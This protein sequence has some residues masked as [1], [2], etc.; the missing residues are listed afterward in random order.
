MHK[1]HT[2]HFRILIA[3]A[4][5]ATLAGCGAPGVELLQD[6]PLSFTDVAGADTAEAADVQLESGLPI[7]SDDCM[8][9]GEPTDETHKAL[10][11]ELNNFRAVN[12]LEPL[13]YSVRLQMAAD[14]HAKDLYERE[15]FAH[16]NPDG[17]NP[18]QRAVRLGFCHEYVGENI[19]AGQKSVEAAQIAWENSPSH[20]DNMLQARYKY[21]G[22][23]VYQDPAGRMYWAQELAYEVP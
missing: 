6:A 5:A 20:R 21:V 15:F 13:V 17:E 3:T 22:V 23:G 12:G 2:S 19:A 14:A 16:I 9:L 18:G 11:E 7:P 8:V 10:L 4:L 1:L